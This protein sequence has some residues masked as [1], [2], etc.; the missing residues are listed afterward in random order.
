MAI[1]VKRR[2]LF[3]LISLTLPLFAGACGVTNKPPVANAGPDKTVNIGDKVILNGVLSYD[4]EGKPLSYAWSFDIRPSGSD[5]QLQNSTSVQCNFTPDV[6]GDYVVRLTVSD[7]TAKG[8]DTVTIRA[9][10]ETGET[11]GNDPPVANAGADQN[12]TVGQLVTLDGSGS[13][14]PDDDPLTYLWE[15]LSRPADS[16]ATLTGATTVNP[17]FTPDKDGAYIVQLTVSDGEYIDQ[18]TVTV[19]ASKSGSFD[20]KTFGFTLVDAAY[21]R[22][23]DRIIMVEH[24]PVRTRAI[25]EEAFFLHI[26]DP[27][28]KTDVPVRLEMRP[29]CLAISPDGLSAVVGHDARISYIADL[30]SPSPSVRYLD[31]CPINVVEIMLPGDGYV[32]AF[33]E[34]ESDPVTII[35]L[36]SGVKSAE[37]FLEPIAQ[38]ALRPNA[39]GTAFAVDGSQLFEYSVGAGTITGTGLYTTDDVL[40]YPPGGNL[41]FSSDGDRLITQSAKIYWWGLEGNLNYHGS[42]DLCTGLVSLDHHLIDLSAEVYAIIPA[43]PEDIEVVVYGYDFHEVKKIMS[44]PDVTY[45]GATGQWPGRFVFFNAAGD[46]IYVLTAPSTNDA[47][48]VIT[49]TT[50]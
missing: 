43:S 18:D 17:S 35:D 36:A 21:S 27:V 26:Y 12:V 20:I 28:S 40:G 14:D 3:I 16:Q 45:G 22:Q 15:M 24:H 6:A 37:I 30:S 8:Y 39:P 32:Y 10:S 47:C 49:L 5:A 29:N 50:P 2:C 9:K 7:G 44:L 42:L 31:Q 34:L 41:W 48:A 19:T 38:I 33:P 46:R 13:T 11:P 23:L 25:I 4:P 1:R